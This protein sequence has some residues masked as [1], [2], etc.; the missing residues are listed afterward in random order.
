MSIQNTIAKLYVRLVF[1]DEGEFDS[2]KTQRQFNVP[3]PPGGIA[4]RSERVRGDIRAFWIDKANAERGVLVYLH[5][6]AYYFGPVKE[7]WQYLAAICKRTQ[8]A[9]LM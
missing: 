7:H 9:G 4:N 6:G 2:L 1:R 5:G 8:M 3:D